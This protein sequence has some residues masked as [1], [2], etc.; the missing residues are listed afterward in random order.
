MPWRENPAKIGAVDPMNQRRHLLL[1]IGAGLATGP[2]ARAQSPDKLYR[3]GWLTSSPLSITPQLVEAFGAGMRELGWIEGRHY[4]I[5]NLY[6]EGRNERLPALAA[7]LVRRRVDLIVCAG[8]ATTAAAK[9][10]TTTIPILF[11]YVVDPVGAK[12]V[13]SL[14][15]PEGN[16]TGLGGVGPG[17][18][19]KQ[20]ELLK[21]SVPK[22]TRIGIML[23][24][25]FGP[26]PRSRAE[27]ETAARSLG[28]I[29]RP[30]ELRAP[31]DI[32]PAFAAL[33]RD[34]VDALLVLGQAF[35]FEHSARFVKLAIDRRL[36]AMIPFAEVARDGLLLAYGWQ[37][38]DDVRRLPRFIDRILGKG[39]QPAELPVEQPTVFRLV[40]NL[41]TAK[42]IGVAV[43]RSV[44]L[45]ADEVIE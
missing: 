32:E 31:G 36:P 42:A 10:A 38:I 35:L 21:A 44:L 11:L 41:K 23:D 26:H 30:I 8:S 29:L 39:V 7:E 33:A 9:A 28:V 16:V 15:H 24:S 34:P 17:L 3:I 18:A 40:V 6:S 2:S 43:P 45:R 1:L 25:T 4:A 14:A 27:A 13:T 5:E 20:L 22:A 19:A 12:L 37:I